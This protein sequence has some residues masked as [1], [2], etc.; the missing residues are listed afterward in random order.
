MIL[1][2]GTQRLSVIDKFLLQFQ[3]FGHNK[4]F[5]RRLQHI[6][7]HHVVVDVHRVGGVINRTGK[8]TCEF[9]DVVFFS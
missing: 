8:I 4:I 1:F 5:V 3:C 6:E 2:N 7:V 9:T